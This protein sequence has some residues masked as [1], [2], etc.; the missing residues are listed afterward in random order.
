MWGLFLKALPFFGEPS[1]NEL[2]VSALGEGPGQDHGF[3]E[4]TAL[5]DGLTLAESE[6]LS[7]GRRLTI[8]NV[9]NKST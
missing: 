6:M 7:R 4:A 3:V 8:L 1:R 5:S 2:D 9:Y